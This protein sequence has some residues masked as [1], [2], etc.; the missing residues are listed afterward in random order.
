MD[1]HDFDQ[2]LQTDFHPNTAPPAEHHT[3]VQVQVQP[4]QE[5]SEDVSLDNATTEGA[6]PEEYTLEHVQ[7]EHDSSAIN[8]LESGSPLPQP[9]QSV[10]RE[11]SASDANLTAG[12]KKRKQRE[13]NRLAAS[14]SRRKKQ[15]ELYATGLLI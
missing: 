14:R 9:S 1:E 3:P 2:I 13:L 15:G 4:V 10:D 6:K 8:R 12:E 11:G 7:L 5:V